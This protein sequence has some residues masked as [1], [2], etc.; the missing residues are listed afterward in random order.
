MNPH[1]DNLRHASLGAGPESPVLRRNQPGAFTLIELLVVIAII[2]ILAAM[3]LPAL[4]RAKMKAQQIACLSN[5]K[6]LSYAWILYSSDYSDRVVV[7]ANNVAM[8]QG[9][10]GW[11]TNVMIWDQGPPPQN[12]PQNYDPNCLAN[13]LLGPYSSRAVG[14]YHCPGDIYPGYQGQRSRSISMNGQIGGGVVA[15]LSGQGTVVNQY[16]TQNWK[17]FNK[18]SDITGSGFGPS[19][20]WVFIDEHADSIN[21]GLFR[22]DMQ[23]VNTTPGGNGDWP[24]YPASN[25]GSSGAL[26]FAD[27]HAEVHKWTDPLSGNTSGIANRPVQHAKITNLKATTL[28]DL[29]WLQTRTTVLQ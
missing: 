24:D 28:T 25:H 21:D 17:I 2:A 18:Q 19:V 7:N 15:T 23:N 20:A 26:A 27:G 6:Q 3:L 8:A 10:D 5:Q 11:V 9:I 13:A 1:Q 14:I 22:I 16:G 4:S 29:I 12:Y